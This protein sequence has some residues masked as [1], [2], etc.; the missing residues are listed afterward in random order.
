MGN[1][2]LDDIQTGWSEFKRNCCKGLAP[3]TV[4]RFR[5]MLIA[6]LIQGASPLGY[7]PPKLDE[8]KFNNKRVRYLTE[9]HAD[10]LIAT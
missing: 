2:T 3:A 9:E 1:C 10:K 6:P 8:I 5:S 4:D 7:D